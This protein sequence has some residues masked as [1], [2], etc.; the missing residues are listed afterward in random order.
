LAEFKN[1]IYYFYESG[2]IEYA[3]FGPENLNVVHIEPLTSHYREIMCISDHPIKVSIQSI[4]DLLDE[5]YITYRIEKHKIGN[6]KLFMER[7]FILF[8]FNN[9]CK[10]KILSEV[11]G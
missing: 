8:L 6:F 1:S 9:F 3:Y 11:R 4:K 5:L 10:V 7:K 2:T